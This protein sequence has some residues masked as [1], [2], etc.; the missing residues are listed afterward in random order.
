MNVGSMNYVVPLI[1][2]VL[3]DEGTQDSFEWITQ[4]I[5]ILF[6]RT[7]TEYINLLVKTNIYIEGGK[8]ISIN[9]WQKLYPEV[10]GEENNTSTDTFLLLSTKCRTNYNI[11]AN[12]L[13]TNC[14][15][16]NV[17]Y[18]ETTNKYKLYI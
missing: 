12:T 5:S 14:K 11:T 10:E 7:M 13:T 16:T 6:Y 9:V 4:F 2:K 8:R 18:L 3:E 17:K 1:Y 15:L